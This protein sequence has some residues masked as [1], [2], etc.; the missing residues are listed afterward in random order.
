M[1]IIYSNKE[2]KV[3]V[4]MQLLQGGVASLLGYCEGRG[5]LEGFLLSFE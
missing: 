1:N 5:S 2:N 4:Q 3:S